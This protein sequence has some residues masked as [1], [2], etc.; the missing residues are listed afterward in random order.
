MG[1]Q[2]T[3]KFE[4]KYKEDFKLEHTKLDHILFYDEE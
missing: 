2:S 4:E 1:I 3:Q